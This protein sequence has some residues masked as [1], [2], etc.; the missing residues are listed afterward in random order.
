MAA[1]DNLNS[2]Q[3]GKYLMTR[4]QDTD[5]TNYTLRHGDMQVG[6]LL[7]SHHKQYTGRIIYPNDPATR[8]GKYDTTT[9][10]PE[11]A[12]WKGHDEQWANQSAVQAGVGAEGDV[13]LPMFWQAHQ[14][15][16]NE[17]FLLSMAKQHRAMTGTM[18]GV[19]HHD[20]VAKT[21]LGLTPS[22]NLSEHSLG[23]ARGLAE[24]GV[25]SRQQLPSAAK[26]DITWADPHDVSG[27]PV[28]PQHLVSR[29]D[30]E[31]GRQAF[32][33]KIRTKPVADPNQGRLF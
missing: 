13:Q 31:A 6:N 23:M 19:A 12:S 15:K 10:E 4:V 32:R 2:H 21:G 9:R 14:P 17:V 8:I 29:D 1:S 27:K 33:S 26:N 7:V 22:D 24:R 20:A 3:H 30:M 5:S 25:V 11:E 28:A 18:L 16:H